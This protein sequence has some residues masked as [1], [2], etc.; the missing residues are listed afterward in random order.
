[1]TILQD[2]R[3]I[4]EPSLKVRDSYNRRNRRPENEMLLRVNNCPG[5]SMDLPSGPSVCGDPTDPLVG[6]TEL[7]GHRAH[8]QCWTGQASQLR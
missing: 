8:Q 1:M 5:M 2:Q 4:V 7:Q 6:T 3:I